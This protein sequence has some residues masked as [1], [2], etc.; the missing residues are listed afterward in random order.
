MFLDVIA[1]FHLPAD[2]LCFVDTLTQIG[3]DEVRLV[4]GLLG[5]GHEKDPELGATVG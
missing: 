3:K 5:G 4:G 2:E 1:R